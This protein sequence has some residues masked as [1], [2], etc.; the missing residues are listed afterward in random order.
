MYLTPATLLHLFLTCLC[1]CYSKRSPPFPTG[2]FAWI[3]ALLR[4]KDEDMKIRMGLDRYMFLRLL[5]MGI[6]LFAI[7]T[8]FCIPILIPLNYIDGYGNAGINILTIGN[9]RY[10]ARTWAHMWLAVLVSGMCC[11]QYLERK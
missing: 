5:R 9:V 3:P 6:V 11:T 2:V 4:T 8:F 7:F 10:S 1:L